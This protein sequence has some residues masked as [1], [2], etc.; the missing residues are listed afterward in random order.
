MALSRTKGRIAAVLEEERGVK[1]AGWLHPLGCKSDRSTTRKRQS[2]PETARDTSR[3]CKNEEFGMK[4][5]VVAKH[6]CTPGSK[7]E[8]LY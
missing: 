4:L 1:C 6:G 2:N 8:N 3:N 7:S 5:C